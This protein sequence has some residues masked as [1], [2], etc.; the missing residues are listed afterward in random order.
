MKP[1]SGVT[2][3]GDCLFDNTAGAVVLLYGPGLLLRTLIS[4]HFHFL[5]VLETSY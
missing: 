3:Q 5:F 4:L 2:L 1:G